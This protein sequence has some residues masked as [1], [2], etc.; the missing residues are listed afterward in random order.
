MHL[1]ILQWCGFVFI[2]YQTSPEGSIKMVQSSTLRVV[3]SSKLDLV[4]T[5]RGHSYNW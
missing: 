4:G 5:L 1:L 3:S 2:K